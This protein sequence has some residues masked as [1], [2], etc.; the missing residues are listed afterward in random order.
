M[1]ELQ[2]VFNYK[3]AVVRTAVVGGRVY[4]VGKDVCDILEI[5]DHH[6]ALERIKDS[7]KGWVDVPTPG[8]NQ[9][10]ISVTE[11]GLYRLV[12]TSRK[13]EAENFSDWVCEEVLPSIRKTGSYNSGIDKAM[14]EILNAPLDHKEQRKLITQVVNNY[15]YMQFNKIVVPQLPKPEHIQK[16]IDEVCTFDTESVIDQ[17]KLYHEYVLWCFAVSQE[18][19]NKLTFTRKIESFSEAIYLPTD[20]ENRLN[21]RFVGIS[22]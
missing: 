13:L 7:Q 21:R 8:G 6:Q 9:K 2:K 4:F 16:F 22:I 10:A 11:A 14:N 1:N 17:S 15:K 18:P 20:H 5:K 3:N 19:Y 12:F